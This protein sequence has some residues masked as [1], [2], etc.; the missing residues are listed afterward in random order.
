MQPLVPDLPAARFSCLKEV[1]VLSIQEF[2]NSRI[3]C[4]TKRQEGEITIFDPGSFRELGNQ[5]SVKTN[6]Q[7]F[8]FGKMATSTL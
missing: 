6:L 1:G 8:E 4:V 2:N 5:S 3:A 7:N